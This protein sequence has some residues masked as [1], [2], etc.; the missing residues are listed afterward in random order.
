METLVEQ[1]LV[2]SYYQATPEDRQRWGI[3]DNMI[4]LS[5][6]IED[7]DEL[8]ADLDQALA[9]AGDDVSFRVPDDAGLVPPVALGRLVRVLQLGLDL[10]MLWRVDQV[11]KFPR[12]VLK[13]EQ[14]CSHHL[15]FI[16]DCHEQSTT[17]KRR[18]DCKVKCRTW[19]GKRP[20]PR[21]TF[22]N[23]R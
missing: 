13:V 8:V 12:I 22:L 16:V 9:P 15:P 21:C 20:M 10:P 23:V 7:T 18:V 3:S 5:C 1:P 19:K 11:V 6:G 17:T 4:R 14:L 2:M